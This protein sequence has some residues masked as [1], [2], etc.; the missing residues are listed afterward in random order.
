MSTFNYKLTF[1]LGCHPG[2]EA[3]NASNIA[4]STLSDTYKQKDTS[5]PSASNAEDGTDTSTARNCRL[6]GRQ[7]DL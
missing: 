5:G 4:N 6:G 1:N 2:L 3:A 7:S